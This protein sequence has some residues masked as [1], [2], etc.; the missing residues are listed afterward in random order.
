MKRILVLTQD[1]REGDEIA[2]RLSR[3]GYSARAVRPENRELPVPGAV[4]PDLVIVYFSSET[5]WAL[6]LAHAPEGMTH[7]PILVVSALG[8]SRLEGPLRVLPIVSSVL[9]RPYS[10]DNFLSVVH[11][12]LALPARAGSRFARDPHMDHLST[13]PR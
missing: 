12:A 13:V 4:T 11:G 3:N 5:H 9:F 7:V 6:D 10:A 1:P 8:H 2:L